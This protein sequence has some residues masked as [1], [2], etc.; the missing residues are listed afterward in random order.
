MPEPIS[1]EVLAEIEADGFDYE[2]ENISRRQIAAALIE[3]R[4]ALRDSGARDVLQLVGEARVT[5]GG[6]GCDCEG[7]DKDKCDRCVVVDYV[8][9]ILQ[10]ARDAADRARKCLGG[11]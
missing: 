11:A 5:L 4:G 10:I 3:A 8:E 2:H 9:E 7:P 1:D 6:M